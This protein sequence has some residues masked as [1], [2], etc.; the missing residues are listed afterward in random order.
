MKGNYG[1]FY[2]IMEFIVE[3]EFNLND[4]IK[5]LVN[6]YKRGEYDVDTIFVY[7]KGELVGYYMPKSNEYTIKL[8]DK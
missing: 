8:R 6:D 1:K 7:Y 3:D 2:T 4:V 5:L